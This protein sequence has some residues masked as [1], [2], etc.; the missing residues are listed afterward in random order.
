MRI[1]IVGASGRMAREIAIEVVKDPITIL[2]SGL[3]RAGSDLE[4]QKFAEIIGYGDEQSGTITSN[5]DD[6]VEKCDAIIDF[7]SP[8]LSLRIAEKCAQKKKILVCGTTGFSDAQKAIFS[9]YAKDTVI[10]WSSNMSVGVNIL[11]NLSE[12]L[13]KILREDF[14]VEIVEMHHK[15]KVD[16]PSGTALCLGAAVAKGRSIDLKEN[17]AMSRVGNIKRQTGEIGFA[18]L[19]CGDVIGDH[20]V[21]FAADGERIEITHKASNRNIFA[22][23]AIRAAIWGSAQ[24][25]GFYSMRDVLNK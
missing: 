8:E 21:I 10:I 12:Q 18:S 6:F 1:G 14:D 23:G 4:G 22:K 11:L 19:R 17:A 25:N 9:S 2:S 15:N 20:T 5:I 13:G 3:V 24:E 16:A 7:T